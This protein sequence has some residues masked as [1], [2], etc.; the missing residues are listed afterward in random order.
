MS[1][2]TTKDQNLLWAKRYYHD[3]PPHCWENNEILQIAR[4]GGWGRGCADP[5]GGL[6]GKVFDGY[7]FKYKGLPLWDILDNAPFTEKKA[8]KKKH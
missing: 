3:A 2:I 1:N 6:M 4:S 8:L 5:K 7:T